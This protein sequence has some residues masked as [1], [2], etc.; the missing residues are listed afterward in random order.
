M[1]ESYWKTDRQT[2][3]TEELRRLRSR[4]AW[5]QRAWEREGE[6]DGQVAEAEEGQLLEA[7]EGARG[8]YYGRG[9]G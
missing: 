8:S 9:R 1:R 2:L 3:P 4:Q 7:E 6:P 5:A